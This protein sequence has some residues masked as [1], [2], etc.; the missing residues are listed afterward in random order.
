[1]KAKHTLAGLLCAVVM[2]GVTASAQA[3]PQIK[4]EAPGKSET[5]SMPRSD[6]PPSSAIITTD[7]L[8]MQGPNPW[9]ILPSQPY[10][11]GGNGPIGEEA[12]LAA[13]PSLPVG[14]G[15]LNGNLYTGWY[16]EVGVRSLFFNM[17]RDAAWTVTLGVIDIWNDGRRA[18]GP[19]FTFFG[20]PVVARDYNRWFASGGLGR[21]WFLLRD[22]QNVG[23]IGEF[24]VGLEIGGRWGTSHLDMLVKGSPPPNDYV[25]RQAV[26]ESL[27]FSAHAGFEIPLGAA[28]FFTTFRAEYAFN[29]SNNITPGL[30]GNLD[31]V[32]LVLSVGF[33]Y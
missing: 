27:Y 31:D 7:G 10:P 11:I 24:R 14:G 16:S 30:N 17:E 2:G 33:R 32:N 22:P 13:G 3:Q 4:P 26:L 12:F 1:M 6:A 5:L 20:L 21:D 28:V 23:L 29:W 18:A 8:P 19:G 25:R 15:V 9:T